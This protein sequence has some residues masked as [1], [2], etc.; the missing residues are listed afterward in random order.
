[1]AW[2][3]ADGEGSG[4][5]FQVDFEVCVFAVDYLEQRA[6]ILDVLGAHIRHDL[7]RRDLA[8]S[9]IAIATTVDV[10]CVQLKFGRRSVQWRPKR[11]SMYLFNA[12]RKISAISFHLATSFTSGA[13]LYSAVYLYRAVGKKEVMSSFARIASRKSAHEHLVGDRHLGLRSEIIFNYLDH[14]PSLFVRLR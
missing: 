10:P 9:P 11:T 13:A 12:R 8:P 3:V 1:L 2:A 6:R 5:H 14:F 7:Q 4:A